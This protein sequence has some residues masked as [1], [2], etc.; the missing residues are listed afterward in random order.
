MDHP[1]GNS[2]NEIDIDGMA[3]YPYCLP[4]TDNFVASRRCGEKILTPDHSGKER[5]RERH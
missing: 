4:P 2:M 5:H 1:L 3:L